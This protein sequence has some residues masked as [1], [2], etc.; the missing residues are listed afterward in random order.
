MANEEGLTLVEHLEELRNRLVRSGIALAITTLF[1]LLFTSRFLKLLIAPAGDIKPVFLRPTEGFITYMRV[2]LLSGVILA[3]PVI[4]YQVI[5][6]ITPGLKPSEARYVY[7]VV[8]GALLSF[9]AGVS[10]SY[11]AMLPFALRYLLHFG[12]EYAVANWAIGEYIDFVTTLMFWVGVVFETPLAVFFLTKLHIVNYQML[13]KNRKW[14]ILVSAIL[15][16]VITPTSD[17]FNMLM[18]MVPLVILY[19][20][21]IWVSRLA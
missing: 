19:E 17:P 20:I 16:A 14:A 1:S 11:F 15:A 18:L 4:V 9:V 7:V 8:P 21:S 12:S 2:A 6:F 3:L 10:F 13:A 5:R